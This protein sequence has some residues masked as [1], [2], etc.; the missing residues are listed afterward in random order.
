[1]PIQP[2][3][4]FQAHAFED[5]AV[6]VGNL[7]RLP[8]EALQR[9]TKVLASLAAGLRRFRHYARDANSCDNA[10]MIARWKLPRVLVSAL[11]SNGLFLLICCP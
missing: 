9:D 1:L 2:H 4:G 11:I 10:S 6:L 5:I 7:K 8:I 3:N